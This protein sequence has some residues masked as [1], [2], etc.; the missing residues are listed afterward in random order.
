MISNEQLLQLLQQRGAK[1]SDDDEPSGPLLPSF[2]VNSGAVGG[3]YKLWFDSPFI[4]PD[5]LVRL[6]CAGWNIPL[7]LLTLAAVR[8]F[9]INQRRPTFSEK[10]N[11]KALEEFNSFHQRDNFIPFPE[12]CQAIFTLIFLF[13]SV[14]EPV[15]YD[16]L[17]QDPIH[18]LTEHALNIIARCN[19]AN[20]PMLREYDRR[21]RAMV[22]AQRKKS[23]PLPF[24]IAKIHPEWLDNVEN[25]IAGRSGAVSDSSAALRTGWAAV[26][27]APANDVLR[28]GRKLDEALSISKERIAAKDEVGKRKADGTWT[29][30][31]TAPLQPSFRANSISG[32][33]AIGQSSSSSTAASGSEKAGP[34]RICVI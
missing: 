32:S 22:W 2:E 25:F 12:W 14:R 33:N 9:G 29:H 11:S 27:E 6:F 21:I 10:M 7:S 8:D 31:R 34:F 28:V 30:S 19:S 3:I 16:S 5:D 17:D 15:E 1:P 24:S 26:L 23:A 20:W 4:I 13:R 18:Q